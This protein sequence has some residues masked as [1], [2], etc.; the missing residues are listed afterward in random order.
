M[1]MVNISNGLHCN[2]GI[3]RMVTKPRKRKC[4]NKGCRIE[5]MPFNSLQQ[6]CSGLCGFEI[7]QKKLA[8]KEK[9]QNA[10]KKKIEKIE[11]QILK[12]R[13]KSIKTRAQ[14]LKEAQA[15]F[16]KFIRLRDH[17]EP[18]VC[19]NEYYG[20]QYH[21]GHYLSV[22]AHPE[23]RFEEDNCHK[24]KSSCNNFKSGNQ[25]EYRINLI[26]KIGVERVEWLEG[27]HDLPKLTIDEIELIRKKYTKL[28]KELEKELEE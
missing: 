15:A 4:K 27:A 1:G 11:R 3:W 10:A 12:A 8:N 16:N 20:G 18:C 6:W 24:Q 7:S 14:Y 13:K 28:S 19:C 26:E 22:G 25:A 5:F 21:A 23:L 9:K 2:E 17:S